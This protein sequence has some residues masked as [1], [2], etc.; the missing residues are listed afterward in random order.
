MRPR[1]AIPKC[2]A[3][4]NIAAARRQSTAACAGPFRPRPY[5]RFDRRARNSRP[6]GRFFSGILGGS[7]SRRLAGNQVRGIALALSGQPDQLFAVTGEA[8]AA[9][10]RLRPGGAILVALDPPLAAVDAP[11]GAVERHAV[12]G[13]VAPILCAAP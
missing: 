8:V 3:R 11:F 1:C 2:E 12:G 4:L 10:A 6:A 5:D 13:E 9:L 7:K